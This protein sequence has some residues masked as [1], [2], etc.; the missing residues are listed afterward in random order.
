MDLLSQR[1]ANPYMVMDDFIRLGQFHEFTV[2]ILTTIAEEKIHNARWEYYIHKV[3]N[4]SFDE[5]IAECKSK[6]DK[7]KNNDMSVQD[8]SNIVSDSMNMLK[9]FKPE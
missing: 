3:W 4:M 5:Y 7:E 6:Q 2:D 8:I 1:Y 9:G